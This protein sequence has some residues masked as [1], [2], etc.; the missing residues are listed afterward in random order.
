M[1]KTAT[2]ASAGSSNARSDETA[3]LTALHHDLEQRLDELDRHLALS[4]EEQLERTRLKKEKLR[5]KDRLQ[6][7]ARAAGS[8]RS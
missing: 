7:L 6:L 8:P 5:V 3:K 1:V 4:T 2:D